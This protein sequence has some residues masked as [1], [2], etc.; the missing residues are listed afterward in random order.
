MSIRRVYVIWTHPLFHESIRLLL[1]HT[2]IH[3]VGANSDYITAQGEILNLRPDTILIEDVDEG[4]TNQAMKVL[5][6][7]PWNVTVVLISLTDNQLNLYH[8]EQRTV[9]RTDDL[10]QLI[11]QST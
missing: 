4:E 11:L 5:K 2:S 9:G 6:S 1:K 10:L 3:F 8:H 7:C